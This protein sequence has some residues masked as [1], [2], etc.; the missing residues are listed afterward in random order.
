MDREKLIEEARAFCD[1]HLTDIP[2]SD[3][4]IDLL[5]DFHLSAA[6]PVEIDG[7]ESLPDADIGVIARLQYRTGEFV[8]SIMAHRSGVWFFS[9]S[10]GDLKAYILK[11]DKVTAWMPIPPFSGGTPNNE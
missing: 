10:T 1:K 9:D 6:S 4:S 7:P 2:I 5:V 3:A 8:T 11:G